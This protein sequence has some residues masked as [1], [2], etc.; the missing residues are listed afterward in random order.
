MSETFSI[1]IGSRCNLSSDYMYKPLIIFPTY[2]S[3]SFSFFLFLLPFFAPLLSLSREHYYPHKPLPES[4]R[5]RDEHSLHDGSSWL[6]SKKRISRATPI[7]AVSRRNP[8]LFI[9]LHWH[10]ATFTQA[11]PSV[12]QAEG[13]WR[14]GAHN[15]DLVSE[16]DKLA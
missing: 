16:T 1:C 11:I 8:R 9:C 7:M 10:R 5:P 13:R 6:Y 3:L 15:S 14:V 2:L 12:H 4:W